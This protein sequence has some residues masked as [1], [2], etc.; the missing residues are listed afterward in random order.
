MF[1]YKTIFFVPLLFMVRVRVREKGGEKGRSLEKENGKKSILL[2]SKK[3]YLYIYI[4]IYIY[5]YNKINLIKLSFFFIPLLFMVR[6][7]V[8]ERGGERKVIG[9]G[10]WEEVYIPVLEEGN[11]YIYLYIQ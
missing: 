2:S 8:R 5:L 11:I 6:V 9:E 1:F 10:E 4:Y 3:V 7:R